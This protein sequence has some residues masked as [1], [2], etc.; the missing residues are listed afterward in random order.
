MLTRMLIINSPKKEI[1]ISENSIVSAETS[2]RA[3][4]KICLSNGMVYQVFPEEGTLHEAMDK[5]FLHGELDVKK[6]SVRG[7]EVAKS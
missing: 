4:F 1:R 5:F 7:K 6:V 3:S 2:G